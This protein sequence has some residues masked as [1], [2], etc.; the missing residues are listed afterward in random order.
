MITL[1]G[2]FITL[3]G[4]IITLTCHYY[5]ICCNKPRQSNINTPSFIIRNITL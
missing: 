2:D 4:N 1:S 5:I 3:S